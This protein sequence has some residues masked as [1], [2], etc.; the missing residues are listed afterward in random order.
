VFTG[1][2]KIAKQLMVYAGESNMKRVWLEAGGKSPNIYFED[3]MQAEPAFIEKAAEGLVLAFFNQGEV[4]SANSRLLVERSIHD[5]FVE[6]LLAKARDWQP[7]DPLD[8]ASRAGAIVDR[9][10]TAGILAAIERAQGEGA[11]L[12][13]GGRQLT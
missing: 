6:R 11:T 2:T 1:S 10:Q 13:G 9:R 7:G 8:P 3:I 5:E 12:L 4:C